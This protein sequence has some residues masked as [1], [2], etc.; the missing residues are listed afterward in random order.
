MV[1]NIHINDR[2]CIATIPRFEQVKHLQA[3]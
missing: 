2:P 3:L 1:T